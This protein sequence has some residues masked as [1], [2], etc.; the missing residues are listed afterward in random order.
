M[1]SLGW[2]NLAESKLTDERDLDPSEVNGIRESVLC[3]VHQK[4]PEE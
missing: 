3:S 2:N 4:R 1:R